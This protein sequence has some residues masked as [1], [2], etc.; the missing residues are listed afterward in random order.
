MWEVGNVDRKM[1][2][3]GS[4]AK[5]STRGREQSASM[6]PFIAQRFVHFSFVLSCRA[7]RRGTWQRE[8]EVG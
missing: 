2:K 1:G 5:R 6:I 4:I 8:G 7:S 3:R